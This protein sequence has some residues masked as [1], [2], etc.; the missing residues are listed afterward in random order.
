MPLVA[1]A[2]ALM[3]A[4]TGAYAAV[5]LVDF[6]DPPPS[7]Q[8]EAASGEQLGVNILN[9]GLVSS[10]FS[11]VPDSQQNFLYG[12][13]PDTWNTAGTPLP[14]GWLIKYGFDPLDPTIDR[15][16][17]AKPSV[18]ALPLIYGNAWPTKFTPTLGDVYAFERPEDWDEGADGPFHNDL[19]P[20]RWDN[21]GDGI[22]DGWLLHYGLDPF[23]DGIGDDQLA[24]TGG[25]SVLEAFQHN[26]DP[27]QTDSDG[28]GLTD[29][30][31]IAGPANPSYPDVG[32]PK[33]PPT[34]PSRFST[35]GSGVC[36]GYLVAHGLDP[37]DSKNAYRDLSNSG[38]TTLEKF[39]WSR[40]R[41]P[42]AT[43]A[44]GAGLDPQ[45]VSTTGGAIPDG[46]LLRH[47]LDPLDATVVTL[48]TG[49]SADHT[50]GEW[51][52]R[53]QRPTPDHPELAHVEVTI[54]DEYLFGRP[55]DWSEAVQGPWWGGTDPNLEDTDGDGLPDSVEMRG[56]YVSVATGLGSS[57]EVRHYH[58]NSHPAKSDT[59]G[60]GLSDY[61]VVTEH[62]TDPN[63]RDTDL[64]GIPDAGEVGLG[65]GLDPLRAD[66]A[67]D[68]LP[69]G[70]RLE[71]LRSRAA[72]YQAD[73]TYEYMGEPGVPARKVTDWV[74]RLDGVQHYM[75]VHGI[76]PGDCALT[77]EDLAH[78]FG[79]SGNLNNK[80][81]S[82]DNP[83]LN[84]LDDDMDGDLLNNGWE[85]DPS[86][87]DRASH[88]PSQNG[89][90]RRATDPMNPDTDGDQL[91]D[92]W[93][94]R[95]AD[96]LPGQV[97]PRYTMEPSIW[98]TLCDPTVFGDTGCTPASDAEQDLDEDGLIFT[99][100][101][102][103]GG[104]VNTVTE[105]IP[106]PALKE[107]TYL[108]DP[109]LESSIG[110]GLKDG[111]KVFWA[112]E[113]P[114]RVDASDDPD[115][116]IFASP[117]VDPVWAD[118]KP[119]LN[120]DQS[121]KVLASGPYAYATTPIRPLDATLAS[122]GETYTTFADVPLKA[123][124]QDVHL[125]T[126]TEEFTMLDAQ[127]AGTNP[128]LVA[129]GTAGHDVPDWWLWA[130]GQTVSFFPV[131]GE[132]VTTTLDL[133][134]PTL[135]ATDPDNDGL[136]V[137]EEFTTRKDATSP[138]THPLC[139]ST[140][141]T[142][143]AD[144]QMVG[145]PS[146]DP[147]AIKRN[148][149]T[150]HDTTEDTDHDGLSD[151]QE[152]LGAFQPHLSRHVQT[153]PYNPDTDGDGLLDGENVVLFNDS[154]GHPEDQPWFRLYMD[155]GITYQK[156]KAGDRFTFQGEAS[157]GTHP[158]NP[159]DNPAMGAPAGWLVANDRQPRSVGESTA[160]ASAHYSYGIP[161]WWDESV[162]GPWWG[163]YDPDLSL[164]EGELD[165]DR[166]GLEDAR[167]GDLYEDP[168]PGANHP[169]QWRVLEW[170]VYP[171]SGLL[172]ISEPDAG[173]LPTSGSEP[174]LVQRLLAQSYM[175]P[176]DEGLRSLQYA[177]D[178]VKPPQPPQPCLEFDESTGI[179]DGSDTPIDRI[180]KGEAVFLV[181]RI[182]GSDDLGGCTK[183]LDNGI[184]NVTVDVRMVRSGGP[185]KQS[186]GA[187]FTDATGAFRVP[188]NITAEHAVQI[189]GDHDVVLRG[190]TNGV[191]RWISDP[192]IVTPTN[193]NTLEIS[194]YRSPTVNSLLSSN[195][196]E[197]RISGI[198]VEAGSV[199]RLNALDRVVTGRPFLVEFQLMDSGGAPLQNRVK[200]EWNCK[201]YISEETDPSG[202]GEILLPAPDD[203]C[204]PST[205]VATNLPT[206]DY[207]DADTAT[208]DVT[209]LRPVSVDLRSLPSRIDP[210]D[211]FTING[212]VKFANTGKG[213]AGTPVDIN[214]TRDGESVIGQSVVADGSGGRFT[215]S[216]V[217]PTDQPNGE[218]VVVATVVPTPDTLGD[219][220]SDTMETR[221]TPYFSG[222]DLG[223]LV[224]VEPTS[225]S[226]RLLDFDNT[227]IAD[228]RVLVILDGVSLNLTTNDTGGFAATR[229]QT[230]PAHPVVQTLS[231]D[232]DALFTSASH[233]G[234]RT[235]LVPTSLHVSG[236][237][238]EHGNV[239]NLPIR[240]TDSNSDP[241][242][243]A[244][245]WVTWE[246]EAKR[247][248][249][250]D[251]DGLARFR[252][253]TNVGDGTGT[254]NVLIDYPGS[255]GSGLMP[256]KAS[257][258]WTLRTEAVFDLPASI[259][260][261]GA[262]APVA[263]LVDK[264]SGTP[265][266]KIPVHV[267]EEGY[268]GGKT[269]S[270]MT[271]TDDNGRFVVMEDI[272][273]TSRPGHIQITARFDGND[274]YHPTDAASTV[275]VQALVELESDLPAKIVKGL[276]TVVNVSVQ[277]LDGRAPDDGVINA[278]V[279][280]LAIGSAS[281]RDGMARLDLAVPA[282]ATSG[283]A[284]VVFHYSDAYLHAPT[285][286]EEP[287]HILQSVRLAIEIDGAVPGKTTT[288]RVTAYG[289]DQV[290]PL[291]PVHLDIEGIEGGLRGTTDGDGV[292][293][294]H[295][296]QPLE[297][298]VVAARFAGQ[299]DLNPAHA[300]QSMVP[301]RPVSLVERG[302]SIL[303][304]VLVGIAMILTAMAPVVYRLRMSPLE[305]VLRRARGILRTDDPDVKKIL[306]VYL[307][308]EEAALGH[309]M[310]SRP[311]QTARRLE[312][313]V[314]AGVPEPAHPALD[315][316]IQ[317]FETARYSE[318]K[319]GPLH[320]KQALQAMDS[321]LGCMRAEAG[322]HRPFSRRVPGVEA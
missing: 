71:M 164:P 181:G 117:E 139:A 202:R 211:A 311:A 278:T 56:Y 1:T 200:F 265:L 280:G 17:A 77:G 144:G 214:I 321:I 109:N 286:L 168:M 97:P 299:G 94:I 277:T 251:D 3:L 270:Y 115:E 179:R 61:V 86:L 63:K 317:L 187:G 316:L 151:V 50:D 259:L 281:V 247:L 314:Q 98:S 82:D 125:I 34:D 16:P 11:D 308:L 10:D 26:T 284:T 287:T 193:T 305:P 194:I 44:S 123:M 141:L 266:A 207:V 174:V 217:F 132:C 111:W 43:C 51:M 133:L 55:S 238:M 186:F 119:A 185:A 5:N 182:Y 75:D 264:W 32:E 41:D 282:N 57:A 262:P 54:L 84:I 53:T 95:Y 271:T 195:G 124:T 276:T 199:V 106:F 244:P 66:S 309:G 183:G 157:H 126:G 222:V 272:D 180:R 121:T 37:T 58:V 184:G 100:F 89:I 48:V 233:Y 261:A 46:W 128:Y 235:V 237:E 257:V 176:V 170:S 134:D 28:D 12:T 269:T 252:R 258:A 160:D 197:S 59:S 236:G 22:P 23:D 296:E 234:E 213:A 208:M 147:L 225:V 92:E 273:R 320:S 138:S 167:D 127:A 120:V 209:L 101:Q 8:K 206:S 240:L 15:R 161:V 294:F 80:V 31:E 216:F 177:R 65:L 220:I 72:Q 318:E 263:T 165:L 96:P 310:L 178:R 204:G 231:Y 150:L 219:T 313:A 7:G 74:C 306:M 260:E 91:K 19:D 14:D 293:T 254:V 152:R 158:L 146:G 212:N 275:R 196:D 228:A 315:N 36:D 290:I 249:L 40:A 68:H 210:G 25:L 9:G 224:Q 163:G 189:P 113:Y 230:L 289:G 108:T 60:D 166:D 87:Y 304:W 102:R 90:P 140:T 190:N 188:L 295:L 226:G 198:V 83:V 105:T 149:E 70:V 103:D 242:P 49:A 172:N 292:A 303:T 33:F 148:A 76:P 153:D 47:G 274:H 256:S 171:S 246:D 6:S 173:A 154:V 218:Y 52:E 302:V 129:T 39:E 62:G 221:S 67:G 20:T 267:T 232:G 136:T 175:N 205:L 223:G 191:V 112:F 297:P 116:Y 300:V 312:A 110:D 122:R 45:A 107:Q 155:L 319:V 38:A 322:F 142:G 18:D 250:T 215:A 69:D 301:E 64:D 137:K 288:V 268:R 285:E 279:H 35:A 143:F 13:D 81:D 79:P 118:N 253:D 88:L 203:I 241:V 283:A 192:S 24:G 245:I 201:N 145:L 248:I 162:H 29:K 114:S 229:E 298:R 130:H 291:I 99:Y 169:N 30:E 21:S 4:A 42:V 156:N 227:P 104:R 78:L 2:V 93:E 73:P 27:T 85:H 159:N 131:E 307:H 239:L 135:G 255:V 243:A